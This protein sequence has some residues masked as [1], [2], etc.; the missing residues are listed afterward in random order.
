[1]RFTSTRNKKINIGFEKAIC[2]CMPE[3]GGLYVPADVNDLRR[4]ILF[5]DEKTWSCKM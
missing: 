5:M 1:M 2:D 3:D 4:W